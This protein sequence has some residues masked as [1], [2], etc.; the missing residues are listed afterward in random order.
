ML[1]AVP[2]TCKCVVGFDDIE[3]AGWQSYQ[4]TTFAQPVDEMADHVAS[5]LDDSAGTPG[6][7]RTFAPIPVWRRSV[8]AQAK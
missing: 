7:R 1:T 2:Q 3:Q 8:R 4:L 5:L 6:K